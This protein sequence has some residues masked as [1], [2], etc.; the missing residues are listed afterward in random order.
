MIASETLQERSGAVDIDGRSHSANVLLYP[1]YGAGGAHPEQQ[2]A[3]QVT[4]T[5]QKFL[6]MAYDGLE[7]RNLAK[8]IIALRTADYI[9]LLPQ[10]LD[11]LDVANRANPHYLGWARH[12]YKDFLQATPQQHESDCRTLSVI[13]RDNPCSEGAFRWSARERG[14]E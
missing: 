14:L 4:M 8:M 2:K 5:S 12:S 3:E 11:K 7:D 1:S 13:R 6:D 10:M 9:D